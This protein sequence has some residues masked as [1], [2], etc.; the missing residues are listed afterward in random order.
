MARIL[1]HMTRRI[2]KY[3]AVRL[4]TNHSF[5]TKMIRLNISGN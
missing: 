4:P 1:L 5:I 3:E 2:R